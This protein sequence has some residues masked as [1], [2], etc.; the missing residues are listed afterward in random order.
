ML[1]L[2]YKFLHLG[3]MSE[4]NARYRRGTIALTPVNRALLFALRI[5]L[6]AM[7][8]LL[9]VKFAQILSGGGL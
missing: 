1:K 8:F 3:K 9:V 5:Y 4:I 7:I 6:A 2:I